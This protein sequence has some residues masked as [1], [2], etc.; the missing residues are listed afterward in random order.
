[1]AS[2][3]ERAFALMQTWCDAL[4]SYQVR[5]L[6]TPYLH[7]GLLCPACHGMHGRCADLAYPLVTLWAHT[8]REAY[9]RAAAELVDWTEANLVCEGGYRNDAGNRW[10]GITAFSAMSLGEALLH[11]GGQLDSALRAR[12]QAIFA[13]LC[14]FMPRF[15]ETCE[16]NI[17]YYAGGAALFA[18]AHRLLGGGD[19]LE[20]ARA[21]ERFC[22]AH[23]DA[24]GLFYG[25]GKP[26]DGVTAKG[27]R[28]IDMGYN[29]EESLPLLIQFSVHAQ[30][31]ES[32]NFY[33]ARMR[34]HLAF[35][36]PDGA[37][38]NS[39]G[40]R[41]NKWTY[42]GSRTSDGVL[43]G[44]AHL[45]ALDPLFDRA[46]DAVLGLYE[47]CTHDGLLYGGPMAHDAQEPPCLHH[48]FCH[49]KALCELF[50]YGGKGA[51]GGEPLVTVPDGVS[52]YQNGNL[53]L[54]RV[55]GWR[56]TVSACDFI[57][58]EG[59]DNGG[60]SLTLL[61][62][63]RLGP[64]CAATMAR[65]V[66]SEPLNMQY[67][68]SGEERF[69]LTP[70]IAAGEKM[71]VCDRGVRL[72]CECAQPDCARIAAQGAWF[73]F[74]YEFTERAVRIRA[75]SQEGGAFFLPI[76]ASR[77][78]RVLPQKD[79]ILTGG[80]RV[81]AEGARLPDGEAARQYSQ[82]G[83]FECVR[84]EI[85]LAPGEARTVEITLAEN[86]EP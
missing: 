79:A 63:D 69:C 80:L 46:A 53:L 76:I 35:L 72:F 32:L 22:R 85:P 42:W 17:N 16:P 47:R 25:E 82:V 66:P 31:A 26:L 27:C 60:G 45:A 12:W 44:L 58:L 18:L 65:Y 24:Q 15:Y 34:D 3:K 71:S 77:A 21:L 43:E 57:Y 38:D 28:P 29:L 70:H 50:H 81:R 2:L 55:G 75:R 62:H 74:Q 23:F 41:H 49:A 68:R 51:A 56:A 7:G 73:D 54:C 59:A 20:K 9:L 4:L 33:A 6:A 40:T 61:W 10:M 5:E 39:F 36:L 8:G 30:D 67:L 86:P 78:A 19:W 84:V 11:Y 83:G 14:R 48:A 52:S 13:R 64:L 1:M 37:I